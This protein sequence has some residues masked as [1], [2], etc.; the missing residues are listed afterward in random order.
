[1]AIVRNYASYLSLKHFIISVQQSAYTTQSCDY[2]LQLTF[3]TTQLCNKNIIGLHIL[4]V[5]KPLIIKVP[6]A[7]ITPGNKN[8]SVKLPTSPMFVVFTKRNAFVE[9]SRTS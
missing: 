4:E 3:E 7:A 9:F 5:S 1:M 6:L 2:R 8:L